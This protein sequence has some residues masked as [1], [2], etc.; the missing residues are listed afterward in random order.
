M[1]C[2]QCN[3]YLCAACMPNPKA[4]ASQDG[5]LWGAISSFK[6]SMSSPAVQSAIDSVTLRFGDVVD[7]AAQDMTEMA[8]EMKS[9]ISSTLGMKDD[10]DD[11]SNVQSQQ[12]K[13]P[14]ISPRQRAQATQLISDF[15]Q[16]FPAARVVPN[17]NELE[18][19]WVGCSSLLPSAVASG[20]YDQLSFSDGD[21]AWQP[22]LRVLYALEHFFCKGGVG[23][24]V[25]TAVFHHAG[26][27]L[28]HLAEVP[29]SAEKAKRVILVLSGQVP[30]REVAE[31]TQEDDQAAAAVR[32]EHRKQNA[33]M[34][35]DL[36][37]MAGT[38]ESPASKRVQASTLDLLSMGDMPVQAATA[39]ASHED[40]GLLGDILE[41]ARPAAAPQDSLLGLSLSSAMDPFDP[42]QVMMPP[43]SGSASVSAG[44]NGWAAGALALG[45]SSNSLPR[46]TAGGQA[47]GGPF[48]SNLGNLGS[49]GSMGSMAGQSSIGGMGGMGGAIGAM[50]AMSTMGAMGCLGPSQAAAGRGGP[51]GNSLGGYASNGMQ[52]TGLGAM[53]G[54]GQ[55]M[56]SAAA[57]NRPALQLS[58]APTK[59]S[60]AFANLSHLASG[61]DLS[62]LHIVE[63]PDPFSFVAE[64]TGVGAVRRSK[65]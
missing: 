49:L 58:A 28:D 24:D 4:S 50:G 7:A 52:R 54:R 53:A 61:A 39:P 15:A 22:R 32:A 9:Y 55:P 41:P 64:H 33:A 65:A 44:P 23:K 38:S 36:L 57:P 20:L 45:P 59:R 5:V 48:N 40:F 11:E 19:L 42:K 56:P 1:D 21:Y 17:R 43:G 25:G 51:T 60:D 46:L 10:E 3:Y 14:Q 31:Q 37:D 13:K 8:T 63:S 16:K 29:Q 30:A 6:E 12:H 27:I 35:P 47:L 18:K 34:A 26:G 2:R 62:P